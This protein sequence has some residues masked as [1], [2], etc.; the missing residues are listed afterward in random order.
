MAKIEQPCGSDGKNGQETRRKKKYLKQ[1]V[2]SPKWQKLNK[3]VTPNGKKWLRNEA[4][5]KF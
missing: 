4:Q 3:R 1:S 2:C 5:K